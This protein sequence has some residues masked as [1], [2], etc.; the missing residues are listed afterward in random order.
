MEVSKLQNP[1]VD[2]K[3]KTPNNLP[4][5]LGPYVIVRP[6]GTE[7]TTKGGII[8]VDQVQES[9]RNVTNVGKVLSISE[10]AYNPD[11]HGEKPW[12]SIGDFVM[13]SKFTGVK[14]LISNENG[15]EVE[16]A[17][18]PYEHVMAVVP[19]LRVLE[20]NGFRVTE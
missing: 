6:V 5:P 18:I 14:F 9:F 3:A 8:L 1:S 10:M 4:V 19:D 17:M 20:L 7:K 12:Y 11:I 13:W 2:P 15:Q 16:V